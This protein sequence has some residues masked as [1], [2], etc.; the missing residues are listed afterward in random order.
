MFTTPPRFHHASKHNSLSKAI[1]SPWQRPV[2][3]RTELPLSILWWRCDTDERLILHFDA[4]ALPS[5][6]QPAGFPQG[7]A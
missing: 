7:I 2:S 6:S 1:F 4:Q 5:R 3:L